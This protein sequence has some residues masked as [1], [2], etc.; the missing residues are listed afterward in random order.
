M[1]NETAKKAGK[2]T[3]TTMDRSE[4]GVSII[5]SCVVGYWIHFESYSIK[6]LPT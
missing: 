3:G 2:K 1:A 5:T 4:T 6:I